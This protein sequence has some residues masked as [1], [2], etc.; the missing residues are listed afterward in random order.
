L[1]DDQITRWVWTVSTAPQLEFCHANHSISNVCSRIYTL[2]FGGD[3]QSTAGFRMNRH[4]DAEADIERVSDGQPA[5]LPFPKPA[6]T[7]AEAAVTSEGETV[8]P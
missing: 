8:T 6:V 7:A 3:F 2:I 4:Q 1:E 5:A